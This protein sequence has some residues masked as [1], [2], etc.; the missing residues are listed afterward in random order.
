M[1]THVTWITV[2]G[3]AAVSS[4][5]PVMCCSFP[6]MPRASWTI[7][8][9][10]TFCFVLF[11]FGKGGGPWAAMLFCSL[12]VQYVYFFG[13]YNTLRINSLISSPEKWDF[14]YTLTTCNDHLDKKIIKALEIPTFCQPSTL[15]LLEKK[16]RFQLLLYSVK[17]FWSSTKSCL[18]RAKWG[19]Y[20][21]F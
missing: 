6:R 2:S 15:S 13:T 7:K 10:K 16:I 14:V 3:E 20:S 19:E 17:L 21:I 4:L 9:R 5:D 18:R 8:T 11:L 12:C 1:E